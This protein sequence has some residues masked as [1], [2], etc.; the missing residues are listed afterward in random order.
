MRNGGNAMNLTVLAGLIGGFI[1]LVIHGLNKSKQI[2]LFLIFQL[3]II[4]LGW[5]GFNNFHLINIL[6][7]VLLIFVIYLI[8]KISWKKEK[9]FSLISVITLSSIVGFIIL[10]Q[11]K[12]LFFIL[13]LG[14]D[15]SSHVAFL[16]R[17]WISGKF[18]Y[19]IGGYENHMVPYSNLYNAYPSL[20]M[21][22]WATIIKLSG[23]NIGTSSDLIGSFSL[24]LLSTMAI[25]ALSI[26]SFSR[27]Q[28]RK[29]LYFNLNATI[30]F[31]V[32]GT[33]SA[34]IWCGFPP[35]IWGILVA[36]LVFRY[37]LIETV[38]A[39]H[40]IL[41][42]TL[43][44][45]VLLYSY[46]I[47]F[48]PFLVLLPLAI[49]GN[50]REFK[51]GKVYR[52][53]FVLVFLIILGTV[54]MLK[55]LKIKSYTFALGGIPFPAPTL[56][57]GLFALLITLSLGSRAR[58]SNQNAELI[59]LASVL[60]FG[61][62]LTVYGRI[63]DLGSYYPIKVLYLFL[64]LMLCYIIYLTTHETERNS[65][66][67]INSWLA[68]GLLISI[69]L[70]DMFHGQTYKFA[71]SGTSANIMREW[72]L[73][74]EGD[75]SPFGNKCLDQVFQGANRSSHFGYKENI[76]LS[77][78]PGTGWQTD[79][80]SRWSNSLQGRIDDLV[81]ELTIP[82]GSSKNQSE[83]IESFKVKY[84]DVEVLPIDM[85]KSNACSY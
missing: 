73:V 46:Q 78:V 32:G 82:M 57:F 55:T 44:L 25:L 10:N 41:T 18:E 75:Y 22:T 36:T 5:V 13:A 79:L 80:L 67:L 35:T 33:F 58:K 11:T 53:L 84:P 17:T 26:L 7:L 28:Q 14:Y 29:K 68:P 8:K 83:V 30:L 4:C 19:G 65:S 59:L 2:E 9:I 50:R 1:W 16:Y 40:K 34:V 27:P 76:H 45:V 61:G 54:L 77:Y 60:A 3:I 39:N 21:E 20:Q 49:Y 81:L 15:N 62:I 51:F 23:F 70:F 24:L 63:S 6:R 43:G 64:T 31:L 37:F 72:K 42:I 66:K 74:K 85:S 48:F 38:S 12:K 47:F 56:F 69:L 71:F 52:D